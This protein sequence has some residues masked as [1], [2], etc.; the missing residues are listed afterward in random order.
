MDLAKAILFLSKLSAFQIPYL[1]SSKHRTAHLLFDHCH[2]TII[3]L[4]FLCSI[5]KN[6]GK[7]CYP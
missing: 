1:F 5:S 7:N 2:F 3:K 6:G 4:S